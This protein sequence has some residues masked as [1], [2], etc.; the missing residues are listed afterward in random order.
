MRFAPAGTGQLFPEAILDS[1]VTP[2]FVGIGNRLKRWLCE[3]WS[4]VFMIMGM[5]P[6]RRS[7]AAGAVQN[8]TVLY[9]CENA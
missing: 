8:E 2:K 9:R 5:L 4:D 3:T 6:V 7:R 1:F